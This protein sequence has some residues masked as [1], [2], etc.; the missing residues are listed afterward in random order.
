MTK[1]RLGIIVFARMSS[2][3]LPGKV[4]MDFGGRPLLAHIIARATAVAQPVIV[5]TS[6]QPE[7]AAI[8]ELAINCGV[9]A[10]RASLDDVL[11]RAVDCA[12]EHRLDAFA[13]LCGDRPYFPQDQM[14]YGLGAMTASLLE[15]TQVDMFSN[16]LS[17][18][19]PPGL[20]TE[21]V[22]VHALQ[23]A[24]KGGPTSRH[25]EHLSSY[26]YDHAE[27][28]EIRQIEGDFVASRHLGFAVDTAEDYARLSTAAAHSG[29]VQATAADIA[30]LLP[31]VSSRR[32][33]DAHEE[34]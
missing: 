27:A 16:H 30:G 14:R 34:R 9:T 22:R 25:R 33:P 31:D 10:F 17:G 2:R 1:P 20:S 4:L 21:V 5:A 24:L 29:D 12:H 28:F 15:G 26:L 23:R 11:Q 18:G 7:D 32:L 13:R 8:A 19:P 3:R 6:D